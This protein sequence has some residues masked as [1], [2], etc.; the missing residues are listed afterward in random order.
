MTNPT[1]VYQEPISFSIHAPFIYFMIR[2][3]KMTDELHIGYYASL[4]TSAFAMAQ[5]VSG[6][7]W[8][9]LSDRIGRK[10]VVLFGLASTIMGVFLFGLSKSFAWA[11]AT[12]I[13]SGLFNG[14]ISVLKSMIAELTEN[15]T[16]EKRTR[17]FSLL[18]VTFGLGSIVGAALG[19][20]FFLK[21]TLQ[22]S[23]LVNNGREEAPLLS[24][25][26]PQQQ[27]NYNAVAVTEQPDI[28]RP[29]LTLS[30]KLTPPVLAISILYA[31]TAF[32]MLYFDELLPTWSATPKE[33]GGLG[34]ESREIGTI[35]SYA[36]IVMLLVQV[37]VLHRLTAIFG[38]LNLF[39]LS[40]LSSAFIF[41]A[42][43]LNRLLYQIPDP[44]A[45]GQVGTKFWVWFGLIFCL[46]VKSL[47]QTIA[48]TI[49]VILLNNS[50]ERYDTLGFINGFSQCCNAA[51]RTLSP[52]VAGYIWSRSI[53]SEWI[54]LE[55]RSYL[56]W[57]ILGIIGLITFFAG[58]QLN[59]AYY[60][61]PHRSRG[62]AQGVAQGMNQGGADSQMI[63]EQDTVEDENMAELPQ[64]QG[65]DDANAIV[66]NDTDMND[67][68]PDHA[69]TSRPEMDRPVKKVG[70]FDGTEDVS[71][72]KQQAA[73]NAAATGQRLGL[74][75]QSPPSH[76]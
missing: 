29:H 61:K 1:I 5:F 28:T 55:I 70:K 75:G 49:S 15:H 67:S 20:F 2:D 12:K 36:G 48:I 24:N 74:T 14:N 40:L 66:A 30:E 73:A 50:V 21:E 19:G 31:V 9:S 54:P 58:M 46:T 57:G 47:A 64:L 39:Q 3:F 35:L 63:A 43:G 42:Q 18:Q 76:Q 27:Q 7:P 16:A 69:D 6:M 53:A 37:F 23:K 10:P 68:T 26:D 59:P 65:K 17:A 71:S 34:F 44:T 25:A 60:N 51:M 8:G 62:V 45:D 13:F 32:Q 56:P 4:I 22:L 33:A 41:L 38:L 72:A 11:L 52:A